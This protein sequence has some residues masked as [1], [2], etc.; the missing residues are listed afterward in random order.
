MTGIVFMSYA[1]TNVDRVR[2]LVDYLSEQGISVWWDKDIEPGE[3]FRDA[4]FHV[5]EKASCVI[6]VWTHA[7]VSSDFV[8]SEADR[9]L[10]RGV[11]IPVLL[12]KTTKIPLPF[13][14][15]NY[16]DLSDWDGRGARS[17]ENLQLGLQLPPC[18]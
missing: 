13:T 5:L 9:A 11:L 17:Q 14:E 16:L 1:R 4:I 8:R 6:V 3:R 2:P 15:L 18:R 12:D 10:Q 7:S